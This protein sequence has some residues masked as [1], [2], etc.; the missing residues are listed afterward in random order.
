MKPVLHGAG[1]CEHRNLRTFEPKHPESVH[2]VLQ[3]DVGPPGQKGS[4]SFTVR[5]VTPKGLATLPAP[6]RIIAS[7]K[8]LVLARYDYD[9]VWRWVEQTVAKCEAHSW[10][11]CVELLRRKF[12]WELEGYREYR[13]RY[14]RGSGA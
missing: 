6:K 8:L 14:I 3:I 10:S 7:G 11:G 12:D 13:S 2:L 9:V 5:V 4:T 1:T